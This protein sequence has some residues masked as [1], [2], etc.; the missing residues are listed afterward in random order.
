LAQIPIQ[1]IVQNRASYSASHFTLANSDTVELS[2]DNDLLHQKKENP[3]I[4]NPQPINYIGTI[5][6]SP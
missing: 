1:S 4:C 5:S 2:R 6:S 3:K